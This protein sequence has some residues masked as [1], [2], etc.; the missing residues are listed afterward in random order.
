MGLHQV[1]TTQVKE[2]K[3]TGKRAHKGI[4]KALGS[5]CVRRTSRIPDRVFKDTVNR[6]FTAMAAVVLRLQSGKKLIF[7]SLRLSVT[8]P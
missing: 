5:R 8:T 3:S 6:I 7:S 2:Q 1:S 4:H